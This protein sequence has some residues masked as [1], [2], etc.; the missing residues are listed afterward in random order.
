[1][2]Q[3]I[4]TEKKPIKLWLEEIDAD[5]LT[6][7]K[8][9]ANLPFLF[10]HV[11]IM[12][13]AHVGYGMPIGGVAATEGVIIPNAVGVD[14][15][16]GVCALQTS[17]PTLTKSQLKRVLQEVRQTIPLGFQHHRKPQAG[18]RMPEFGRGQ[19]EKDLPIV[20]REYDS[21]VLQLG[22]LGGG[23][24]FIELQQGDD[25]LLWIMIHSGSRN[26]GYQVAK[27]YNQLA[28]EHNRAHG[29][30]VPGQWQLDY[31]PLDSEPGQRYLREMQYCVEFAAAN[32]SAMLQRVRDILLD[33]EPSVTFSTAFD[34]AHNYAAMEQHF[35]RE[36]LVHRKGATRAWVGEIGL[37]PGSQGSLSYIVRGLGNPESFFSCSHGA[38]RKLGRKQAQRELDMQIEVGRLERQGILHALRHKRD[39]E[40]AAG[41]YK[42]IV[43]VINDQ[44]DLVEVVTTL[45]PLAV[46]KG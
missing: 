35:G 40:E 25:G 41:A 39:L 19:T 9:L 5:T 13:D 8:N 37:I 1:M 16:C 46:V 44:R 30:K 33:I 28:A 45:Q 29:A 26:I 12:P 20:A 15:G 2:I 24:H 27:H 38:G 6:Q 31:L 4:S 3:T 18:R 10:R 21:G 23:N 43:K 14:I 22:T 34:V 32:R 17:L 7:A 42:D 11:A 36:V